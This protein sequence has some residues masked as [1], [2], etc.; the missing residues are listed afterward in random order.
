MLLAAV[1][2]SRSPARKLPAELPIHRAD[3]TGD[4][5]V[6]PWLWAFARLTPSVLV[7]LLS[8]G[9]DAMWAQWERRKWFN[10]LSLLDELLLG[11]WLTHTAGPL[12]PYLPWGTAW[13]GRAHWAL[14]GVALGAAAVLE[15]RRPFAGG[16]EPAV[17]D[18][19]PQL[20]AALREKKHQRW[21][22]VEH[23]GNGRRPGWAAR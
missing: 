17:G 14:L 15:W 21:V 9:V 16:P 1:S 18:V 10:P 11:F 7:L 8:T 20:A 3:G 19:D 13:N 4:D 12:A 2:W 23:H 5:W 22:Y 6:S